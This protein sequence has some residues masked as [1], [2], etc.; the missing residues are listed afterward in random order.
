MLGP[1]LGKGE[2]LGE[3]RNTVRGGKRLRA[4]ELLEQLLSINERAYITHEVDERRGIGEDW[5][6]F[7]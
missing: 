1:D 4:K 6:G 3:G 5:R 2:G 7:G